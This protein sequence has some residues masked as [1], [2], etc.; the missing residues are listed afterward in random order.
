MRGLAGHLYPKLPIR[1]NSIAP[2]WTAT[3]LVPIDL[4]KAAGVPVQ[5]AEVVGRSVALLM[6]DGSRNQQLIYSVSGVYT[7]IETDLLKAADT[8][9]PKPKSEE[10]DLQS[11]LAVAAQLRE[12]K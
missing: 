11:L 6:A 12:K 7:E 2:S 9:R 1:I 5:S 10:E 8:I 4:C 3:G